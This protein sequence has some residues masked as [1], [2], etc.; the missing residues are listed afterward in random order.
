MQKLRWRQDIVVIQSKLDRFESRWFWNVSRQLRLFDLNTGLLLIAVGSLLRTSREVGVEC[1]DWCD[2]HLLKKFHI[3][4]ELWTFPNA[5]LKHNLTYF[6]LLNTE[7]VVPLAYWSCLLSLKLYIISIFR[8][9]YLALVHKKC[10]I[11]ILCV[12]LGGTIKR[13]KAIRWLWFRLSSCP[14]KGNNDL[15]MFIHRRGLRHGAY[16]FLIASAIWLVY[17]KYVLD[18]SSTVPEL[19]VDNLDERLKRDSGEL[20]TKLIGLIRNEEDVERRE[21]GYSQHAFNE[22][23]SERIGFFREVPDT[24]DSR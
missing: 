5:N 8:W 9:P 3:V 23:V 20:D 22:L 12:L 7:C 13:Q 2:L 1:Y 10:L 24:R 11:L 17:I 16:G 14:L 21:M 4:S 19:K 6:C 18:C 15:K